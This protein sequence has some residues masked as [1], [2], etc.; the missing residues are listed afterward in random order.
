MRADIQKTIPLDSDAPFRARILSIHFREGDPSDIQEFLARYELIINS[1][2][3]WFQSMPIPS[4]GTRQPGDTWGQYLIPEV[5]I[6]QGAVIQIQFR[7]EPFMPLKHRL[8][9]V[10]AVDGVKVYHAEAS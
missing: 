5:G 9:W 10:L 1:P 3:P 8:V 6:E 2:S 7:G 4:T